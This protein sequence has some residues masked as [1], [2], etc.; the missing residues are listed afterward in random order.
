MNARPSARPSADLK[1]RVLAAAAARPV[2]ARGTRRAR[3]A[4]LALAAIEALI[5]LY[6]SGGPRHADGRPAPLGSMIALGCAALA[7]VA[8]AAVY[9]RARSMLGPRSAVLWIVTLGTP[10]AIAAWTLAWHVSYVDPFERLGVRCFAMSVGTAPWLFAA[11][12]ALRRRVDPLHP[13][14]FGAAL[15]T[16]AGAWAGVVVVLWCPLADPGHVIRGHLT[17]FIVLSLAG[18]WLGKRLFDVRR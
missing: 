14:L 9:S 12:V 5:V 11:L 10:F 3:W 13:R 7:T 6:A 2:P 4:L 18:A 16:I 15:G 1:A 17:P 8:T